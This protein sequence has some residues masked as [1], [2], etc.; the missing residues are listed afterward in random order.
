MA[1]ND[2]LLTPLIIVL[3]ILYIFNKEGID[4]FL[5]LS[6]K[7]SLHSYIDGENYDVC[8]E[9]TDPQKA[10]NTL[11]KLNTM[12]VEF[13]RYV[14]STRGL[15]SPDMRKKIDA[16]LKRYNPQVMIENTPHNND[17]PRTTSYTTNKGENMYICI[18]SLE[19]DSIENMQILEF[20]VLHEL[21]HVA[22]DAWGHD[23]SF[24]VSFK[25]VL[26]QAAAAG[27]HKPIDYKKHPVRYCGMDVNYNPYF[28]N[29]VPNLS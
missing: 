6:T 18:R 25:W 28:D 21:A 26:Q 16:L 12:N 27:I 24:W 2:P 29:S 19:N 22:T 5:N 7:K 11:A 17:L 3:L 9:F 15:A 1:L 20:V 10:A 13:I 23:T 4:R 14:R 8:S